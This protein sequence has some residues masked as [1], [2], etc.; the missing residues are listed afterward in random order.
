MKKLLVLFALLFVTNVYA[1]TPIEIGDYATV[2]ND[3]IWFSDNEGLGSGDSTFV[4]DLNGEYDWVQIILYGN[5][6]SSIDS[7]NA[8]EG[9]YIYSNLTTYPSGAI[10]WGSQAA[11][12]DS[13]MND[14]NVLINNTTGVSYTLWNPPMQLLRLAFSN[15]RNALTTRTTFFSVIAKRKLK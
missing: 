8:K 11:F 6:N 3:S 10:N 9:A 14:V 5:T 12:K 4:L 2:W 7:L 15:Y 1:Q 13:A